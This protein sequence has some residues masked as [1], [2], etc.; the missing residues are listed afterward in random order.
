[1]KDRNR[2]PLD[3]SVL[4]FPV[5]LLIV[6]LLMDLL[7]PIVSW[8]RHPTP[9]AWLWTLGIATS[10]A[11]LGTVVL[12]VAKLPQYRAGIFLRIGSQYLPIREQRLY[13]ISWWLL[14]P[15]IFVLLALYGA[16]HRFQ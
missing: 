3:L 16:V 12:F 4:L 6:S 8:L 13:R 2:F 5:P 15:S 7:F 9:S 11:V 14:V 1:M 10:A